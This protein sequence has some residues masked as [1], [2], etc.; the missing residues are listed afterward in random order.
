MMRWTF[1][2]DGR[3]ALACKVDVLIV[4]VS[5]DG[6]TDKGEPRRDAGVR[7]RLLRPRLLSW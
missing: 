1:A 5:R 3:A 7:R 4:G 2:A 6:D